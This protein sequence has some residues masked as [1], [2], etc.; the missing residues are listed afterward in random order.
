MDT[1]RTPQVATR[2]E[3]R[4]T[5]EGTVEGERLHLVRRFSGQVQHKFLRAD[6]YGTDS[7]SIRIAVEAD[8]DFCADYLGWR[9]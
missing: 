5:V 9:R 4:L 6:L 8:A 3:G 7:D 1:K 2:M